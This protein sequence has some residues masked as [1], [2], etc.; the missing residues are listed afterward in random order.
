MTF[1]IKFAIKSPGKT[2]RK[3][4]GDKMREEVNV[5]EFSIAMEEK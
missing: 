5:C 1:S 4:I 3:S 2:D